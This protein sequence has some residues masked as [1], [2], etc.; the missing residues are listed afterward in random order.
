MVVSSKT[1]R[2]P[3]RDMKLGKREQ[4]RL[5]RVERLLSGKLRGKI[6]RASELVFD[7]D[8]ATKIATGGGRCSREARP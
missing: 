3:V 2:R 7:Y 1:S 8:R 6:Q 5:E 4:A